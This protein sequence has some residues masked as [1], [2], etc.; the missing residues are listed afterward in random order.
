M[1]RCRST[2]LTVA[3]SQ[4]PHRSPLVACSRPLAHAHAH[5]R[6]A[7]NGCTHALM[8]CDLHPAHGSPS[9]GSF[10]GSAGK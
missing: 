8:L 3:P 6:K 5:A 4:K 1:S 9:A 7:A 10:S 2:L